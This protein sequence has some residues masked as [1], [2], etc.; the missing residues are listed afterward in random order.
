MVNP[1]VSRIVTQ[2]L[3]P[4]IL[5]L[6]AA[7]VAMALA[8]AT[9]GALPYLIQ[10]ATDR[11]FVE[12]NEAFLWLIP[13]VIVV[14]MIAKAIA[15]YGAVVIVT[16]VGQRIIADI[17]IELFAA[18]MK[19]DLAWLT[20]SHTGQ[21]ISGFM[22]DAV[23]VREAVTKT[24]VGIVKDTL[25]LSFLVAIMFITDWRLA[26]IATLILPLAA[27]FI[28]Q[29]G[30]RM[31][32]AA[33]RSLEESAD[34]TTV[35]AETLGGIRVVKAYGQEERETDRARETINRVFG[36]IMKGARARAAATPITE[37]L[38]G[39]A[40]AAV[41]AYGGYQGMRGQMSVGAFMGFVSAMML[42]YQPLK[43]LANLQTALQ[44]GIAAATRVF[45]LL[46][47]E[48]SVVDQPGAA[49]LKVTD[50]TLRLEGVSFEYTDGPPVLHDVTLEV[51]AGKTV[52]LVGPSGAGK[53]TILNLIPRFYDVGA[54]RVT[55]DG[56]AVDG[57]TLDSLRG[58]IGIVTQDPFLFDDTIHAN[59]AYSNVHAT[60]EE[61]ESAARNA[62]AEEFIRQQPHGYDTVVGEGGA[63]LS[64]GQKQRIAIARAMLRNAPILLLDEAT[65][66]L[67]TQSERRVQE[68]IRKLMIGK[69]TLVI[70]HR[71]STVMDA[72][73]IY[74]LEGGR[75]VESGKHAELVDKGGLYARLYSHDLSDV[76]ERQPTNLSAVT[77]STGSESADSESVD[78]ESIGSA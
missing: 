45:A 58:A 7:V 46:D 60:R 50:G 71:L 76:D 21:F 42:A 78:S 51:P 1:I 35:I 37:S 48:H 34:L 49:P 74:V 23:R 62:A 64:G 47:V 27:L 9:T 15:G 54:G 55:I 39:F 22:N 73:R 13:G 52:A 69:T 4:H 77:E 25:T 65:S 67:D 29:L 5:I 44:E 2:Y 40:I 61:V 10:V 43:S 63:R 41:I 3:S 57:V 6:L 11:I 66:A 72:D 56:Q 70:A 68:A 26:L 12:K 17:Q 16:Q 31:R 53:S 59:I 33:R 28:R 75:V 20:E 24:I 36:Y 14:L 8:A 32:K 30:K 19:A 18:L 38:T